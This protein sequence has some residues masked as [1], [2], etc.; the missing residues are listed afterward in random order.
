LD[1]APTIPDSLATPYKTKHGRTVYDKGG[2]EP[3]VITPD[4][5]PSNILIALVFNNIIFDFSNEY[6]A[7]HDSIPPAR[8]FRFSDA[9]YKQFADF[10][11]GKDFEYKTETEELL[12]ELKE[13]AEYEKYY[14]AIEPIYNAMIQKIEDEKSNEIYKF[15]EEISDFI[16]N[17]IVARYYYQRG[18]IEH[19]LA[20]DPDIKAAMEILLNANRYKSI[21]SGKK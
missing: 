16:S 18:R 14:A 9:E 13:I 17:E 10:A 6:A 2:I 11:K 8:Q 15:K 19:Q 7:K 4:S 20:T 1:A 5:M 12:K 3:D 21:L